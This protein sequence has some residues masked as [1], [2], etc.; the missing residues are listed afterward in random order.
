MSFAW[1][2]AVL[3]QLFRLY[4]QEGR[5]AAETARALGCGVSRNAVLGKVQ[6]MGWSRA[7]R[8]PKVAAAAAGPPRRATERTRPRS[9][10]GRSIPLPPLRDL[11]VVGRPKPWTERRAGECA[12]P[13]G[14][15]AQPGM[16]LSCCAPTGGG[17]YC[18]AHRAL[19][20]LPDTALTEKDRD[21]IVEI[22]RR[23]A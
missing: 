9:P 8:E 14:E 7:E 18:P 16:Q 6:R 22:A 17:G 2:P 13:V 20:A 3:D 19:M 23:A 11:A 10:F 15:P 4:I 21:A 1:S 12:F 5:S